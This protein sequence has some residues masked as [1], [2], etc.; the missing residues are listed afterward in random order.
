MDSNSHPP[1]DLDADMSMEMDTDMS[2]RRIQALEDRLHTAETEL[3]EERDRSFQL[4][5]HLFTSIQKIED[6]LHEVDEIHGLRESL[7][8]A[9][10]KIHKLESDLTRSLEARDNAIARLDDITA[11]LREEIETLN[12]EKQ[13][14]SSVD[15]HRGTTVVHDLDPPHNTPPRDDGEARPSHSGETAPTWF[16]ELQGDLPRPP[17]SP[18]SVDATTSS[19]QGD[20]PR[21]P[22]S[23]SS[24]D[25]T[26]S[27]LPRHAGGGTETTVHGPSPAAGKD[28]SLDHLTDDISILRQAVVSLTAEAKDQS[29]LVRMQR[30]VIE[31]QGAYIQSC[32]Q[33][34]PF[35]HNV[36]WRH[37]QR[38]L[39]AARREI[40]QSF[41]L[42]TLL[43]LA[44]P[45][46]LKQL[47]LDASDG[48]KL[49][50][51]YDFLRPSSTHPMP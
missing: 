48:S 2:S 27:S 1:L 24:V 29:F 18:S 19:L 8:N 5:Q 26:T 40:R 28:Q 31:A 25:A 45:S 13:K 36:I 21:P 41:I 23:P 37:F 4:S 35:W 20:L 16:Y 44:V 49:A 46:P 7:S 12:R 10:E 22:L 17:L 32:D 51:L 47:V 11:G 30:L 14:P 39:D 6:L 33:G 43:H 9:Q 15:I 42:R 3:D 50:E 38:E 34:L